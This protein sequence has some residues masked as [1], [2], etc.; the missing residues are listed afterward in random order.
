M[1]TPRQ[2]ARFAA[3]GDAAPGPAPTYAQHTD[4]ILGELGL[5]AARLRG[6]GIVA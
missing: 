3:D 1:L 4:E 5:D 6:A 2:G